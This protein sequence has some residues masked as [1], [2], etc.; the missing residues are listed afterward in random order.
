MRGTKTV[1]R[2]Q[3]ITVSIVF[4]SKENMKAVIFAYH[5]MGCTGLNAL[6]NAGFDI[7]AVFTHADAVGENHFHGSVAQMAQALNIPVYMPEDVNQAQWVK[8]LAELAPDMLFSL[9]FRQILSRDILAC[10]RVGAF[11]VHASLLPA[12]RGRAH[13]NWV[14]IKGETIT[15]VTLFRMTAR[16]DRGPILAQE[17]VSILPADD[18]F[19]LHNKLVQ[20]SGNMLAVWLPALVAGELTERAQ[21]E[22]RASSFGGRK[23][24]DGVINWHLP[25]QEIH[26]LVRG[27][28][29]PWPGAWSSVL[30]Q[31]FVVWHSRFSVEQR[32]AKPGTVISVV[33]FIVACGAGQLEILAGQTRKGSRISGEELARSLMLTPGALLG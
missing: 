15:G 25:A 19:S 5:D 9:S 29:S 18:A 12:H 10:A 33:P 14:L 13:L 2:S 3:S 20:T 16:P 31:G 24:E 27:L 32:D 11:G 30:G 21:D 22:S 1:S 8:L 26:N 4:N 28:A 6:R 17:S 7:C 23:P